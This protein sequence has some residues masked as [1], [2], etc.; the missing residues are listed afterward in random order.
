[1]TI[2]SHLIT[3][4]FAIKQLHA[5]MADVLAA[6]F[7]SD[8]LGHLLLSHI[9]TGYYGFLFLV[10]FVLPVDGD[11]IFSVIFYWPLTEFSSAHI[12]LCT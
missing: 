2:A 5:C 6:F 12:T 8:M 3:T 1:M 11:T 4:T 9:S 10:F 7:L